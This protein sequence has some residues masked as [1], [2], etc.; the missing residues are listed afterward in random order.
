M[1]NIENVLQETF[2]TENGNRMSRF[3]SSERNCYLWYKVSKGN[4]SHLGDDR[5]NAELAAYRLATDTNVPHVLSPYVLCQERSTIIVIPEA[6]GRTLIDISESLDDTDWYIIHRAIYHFIKA[7]SGITAK[8]FG[9][10]CD[11]ALQFTSEKNLM[12]H[13]IL[14]NFALPEEEQ[15]FLLMMLDQLDYRKG[16]ACRPQ[17]VHYDLWG[18]NILYEKANNK[19]HI[20]DLERS[21]FSSVCAEGASLLGFVDKNELIIKLC[22]GIPALVVK[23][24]IYRCIFLAERISLTKDKDLLCQL[25]KAYQHTKHELILNIMR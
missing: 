17:L 4:N 11:K 6:P 12:R 19:V 9:S 10:I 13:M 21:F 23:M 3:W 8:T 20:I 1:I 25:L 7:Y 22:S 5:A 14:F 2:I 15:R 24:L 16:F 18:G